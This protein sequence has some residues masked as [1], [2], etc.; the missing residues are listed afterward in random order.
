[1]KKQHFPVLAVIT[2]LFAVFTLGF[3]LGRSFSRSPVQVSVP[4]QVTAPRLETTPTD[5]PSI[6]ETTEAPVTFPIN[7]NTATKEELMALPGIGETYAQRILD[8]REVHGPF[9]KVGE[10]MNVEGIGQKRL[11]D[12][13][14]L[15]TIGG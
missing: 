9:T 8:Y 3:F 10:L 15:V 13:I 6:P 11:E 7:L 14:D 12:I 2:L 5:S 4:A 1:M